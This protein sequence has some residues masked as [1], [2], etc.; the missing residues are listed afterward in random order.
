M[1]ISYNRDQAWDHLGANADKMLYNGFQQATTATYASSDKARTL[2]LDIMQFKDPVRA[3][4]IFCFLRQ[5]GAQTVELQPQGYIN[6]DTLVFV[7][8]VHVGRVIG[9][10]AIAETDLMLAAKSMLGKLS[11]SVSLP[12][13]VLMFPREGMV[14][15]TETVTLDDIEG[16]TH[17]SN[18]FGA[19]YLSG[20]DTLQLFLQLNPFGGPT[21][22]VKEF[23]GDKGKIKSYL[24]DCGYQALTGQ[25]EQG[26][27]VFCA[28]DKN[29]LCTVVGRIDQKTAQDLVDKTF[30]LA[31]KT[32]QM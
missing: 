17:R 18:L 25:D 11:D 9:S 1:P 8:G 32:P 27:L 20:S 21:L 23:I 15:N 12:M 26:Q 29:V 16:Q 2:T 6:R 3:F 14:P 31:A 24:M 4:A 30:A 5:P 10:D 13:Q 7:K 28:L 22:A 19:E